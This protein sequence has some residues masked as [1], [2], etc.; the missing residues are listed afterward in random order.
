M[1]R[2]SCPVERRMQDRNGKSKSRV[3]HSESTGSLSDIY[4]FLFRAYGPQHWWPARTRVEIVV[5]AILAQNTAWTNVMRAMD[6]L[7]EAKA[8][9]WSALREIQTKNLAE[10]IR[11]SGTYRVKA[12]RLKAFVNTLW[13]D[14]AGS[15]ESLLNG[16]LEPARRQLLAVHGI[17]SETA[18]AILLYAANHP[19]FVVDAYTKR[20]LRRHHFIAANAGYEEIRELFHASLPRDPELFNEYHALIVAVGKKHC[21]SKAICEGCPLAACPHDES[22]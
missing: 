6:N 10:L 22:L 19:T 4:G 20:L 3:T 9:S 17:G 14:H 18:D 7:R 2:V 21:R 12:A 11:P 15:L 16:E 5:G 1:V 8:L 13:N